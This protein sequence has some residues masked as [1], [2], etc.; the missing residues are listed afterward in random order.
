MKRTIIFLILTCLALPLTTSAYWPVTTAE[1]LII[2][3]EPDTMEVYPNALPFSNGSV[4]MTYW[5]ANYV[6]QIIDRFGE[7]EY[8]QAPIVTP[9]TQYSPGTYISFSTQM[10]SDSVG[11]AY[12][13]YC[14]ATGEDIGVWGQHLDSL[15]NRLWGDTGI[16]LLPAGDSYYHAAGDGAGGLLVTC[17]PSQDVYAQRVDEY[18]NLLWGDSGIPVSVSPDY[19]SQECTIAHDGEGGAFVIWEEGQFGYNLVAQHFDAAGVPLWAENLTINSGGS[20]YNS[21]VPDGEGGFILD[22]NYGGYGNDLF[23]IN[24]DGIEVWHQEN[25]SYFIDTG[26]NKIVSGEENFVYLGFYWD[27]H[28][29]GQRVDIRGISYWDAGGAWFNYSL[30]GEY[31]IGNPDYAFRYPNYYIV[32]VTSPEE[33][34]PYRYY[35]SGLDQQGNRILGHNGVLLQ[36]TN[37]DGYKRKVVPVDDGGVIAILQYT[38]QVNPTTFDIHAKRVNPDGSLGGPLHL[39]VELEPESSSIQIP[40]TGGTF[41]YNVA[42]EDTYVVH[43]DFDAWVEVTLPGGDTREITLREGIHI[44]SNSVIERFD[45]VQNV[46][47]WAPTGD[48]TY[49]LYVGDH[50]YPDWYWSKD[51]FWFEKVSTGTSRLRRST[52]SK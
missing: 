38:I 51:E 13:V 46:P 2:A 44:D 37:F 42:I 26:V 27:S 50:D 4:L 23:R 22:M 17:A 21:P 39:L 1:N 20:W 19:N 33:S 10:V 14:F 31:A 16:R 25:L 12:I 48:Y 34:G 11:G 8:S 15:G 6:F 7:L 49:T 40:P 47:G 29:R 36:A 30:G 18:G 35:V 43:S 45:L 41:T 3:N 52:T 5:K 28:F 32:Y 9:G 24:S